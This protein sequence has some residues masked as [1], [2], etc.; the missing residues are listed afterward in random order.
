MLAWNESHKPPIAPHAEQSKNTAA[1]KRILRF[2]NHLD[3]WISLKEESRRRIFSIELLTCSQ[4]FS[5]FH[6][7]AYWNLESTR[8]VTTAPSK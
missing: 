3:Y 2:G 1:P 7:I 5:C 4:L 8:K 6:S